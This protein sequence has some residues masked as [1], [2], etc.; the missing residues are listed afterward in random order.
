MA[1]PPPALPS[2][3]P[4]TFDAKALLGDIAHGFA[5]A[6]KNSP[7]LWVL[8]AL[9]VLTGLVRFVRGIIH[10]GHPKDVVRRFNRAG[11]RVILPELAIAANTT[12]RSSADAAPPAA[13]RQTTSTRTVEAAGPRS[14]TGKPCASD[15]TVRNQHACPGTGSSTAWRNDARPTSFRTTTP[16]LSATDLPTSAPAPAADGRAPQVR[17]HR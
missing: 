10:S 6:I 9:V 11:R 17:A 7:W 1:T 15:I 3:T 4:P 16:S 12:Y 14:A 8:L 2:P 5:T 13:S